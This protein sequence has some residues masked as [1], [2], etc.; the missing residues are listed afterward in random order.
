[1]DEKVEIILASY[2]GERYIEQ[3]I[4]SI[5][6]Q[7]YNNWKLTIFDDCSKDRT[8]KIIKKFTTKRRK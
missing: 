2:N 3:Q 6:N 7:T 8:L 1:M 4:L 5:L